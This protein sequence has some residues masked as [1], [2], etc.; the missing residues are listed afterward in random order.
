MHI[1]CQL[2][3][4]P[5][6]SSELTCSISMSEQTCRQSLYFLPNREL[7]KESL[8]IRGNSATSEIW[9]QVLQ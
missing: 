2:P 9:T 8:K 5:T 6:E 4:L 1:V 3:P 7:P